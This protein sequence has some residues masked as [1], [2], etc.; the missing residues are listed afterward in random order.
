MIKF[1]ILIFLPLVLDFIRYIIIGWFV[2][3]YKA[4]LLTF[5]KFEFNL[6]QI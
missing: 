1:W 4:A 3:N 5:L 2:I 6:F